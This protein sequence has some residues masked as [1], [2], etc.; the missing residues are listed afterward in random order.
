M[1]SGIEKDIIRLARKIGPWT[2]LKTKWKL[3]WTRRKHKTIDQ[4]RVREYVDKLEK[5][6]R[7]W[8]DVEIGM[9]TPS[10]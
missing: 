8:L 2:W 9:D 3:W 5:Y 6:G 7:K 4:D 1:I 10:A